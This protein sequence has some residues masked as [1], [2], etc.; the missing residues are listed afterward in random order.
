MAMTNEDAKALYFEATELLKQGQCEEALAKLDTLDAER[1]N[2]KHVTAMR[3]QCFIRM[4]ELERANTHLARLEGK[5]EPEKLHELRQALQ[6]AAAKAAQQAEDT[7]AP[8]IPE[9]A[10][11]FAIEAVYPVSTDQTSVVGHVQAGAIHQGDNLTITTPDGMPTMAPVIRIGSA[12][13][14]LNLIRAGQQGTLL[15]G[16]EPSLVA[17]GTTAVSGISEEAYAE[18]MMV[19]TSGPDQQEETPIDAEL[20]RLERLIHKGGFEDAVP[21]LRDVLMRNPQNGPAHR[22]LAMI[23]LE[24][25]DHRD[26]K[27]A[28]AA[29]RKAYE[30]GGSENPAVITLLARAL[31]ENGEAEQGLRFME[32]LYNGNLPP[33]ARMALANRI[34]EFREQFQLGHEWELAN[35]YGDVVFTAHHLDEV[36]KVLENGTVSKDAKCRRDHIGDWRP[37]ETALAA[38]HPG[39]AAIYQQKTKTEGISPVVLVL[40]F[41]VAALAVGA[42][43]L[44][45]L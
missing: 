38:E 15:L 28:L 14:P 43:V 37:I 22:L 2:S 39:I 6:A 29:I 7:A 3:V 32:R 20:A 11:A 30:L 8:G 9:G 1:P 45:F 24:S 13:T 18:T 23:H 4:G 36:A 5:L 41:V 21:A 42:G 27:Q 33:E 17:P 31:A 12:D 16:I 35:E 40:A 34:A 25:P 44:L 10:S 19:D 26:T